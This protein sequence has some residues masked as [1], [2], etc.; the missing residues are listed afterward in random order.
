[1]LFLSCFT[2]EESMQGP[3]EGHPRLDRERRSL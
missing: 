1:M 3:G 2:N